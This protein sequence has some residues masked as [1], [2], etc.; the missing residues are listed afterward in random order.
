MKTPFLTLF[1]GSSSAGAVEAVNAI[2]SPDQITE[3]GKLL[4]QLA[5]GVITLWKFLKEMKTLK[6]GKKKNK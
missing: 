3:I 1:I 4:I 2:P 5:I 6:E